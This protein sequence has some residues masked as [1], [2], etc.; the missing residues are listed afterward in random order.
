MT[1]MRWNPNSPLSDLF[2]DLF[3]DSDKERMERKSYEC[4]PATNIIEKN[5]GF[6]LQMAVPG[7]DKKD[8]KIDLEKN[9]LSIT[10][11]KTA[12]EKDEEGVKYSR[13]EFAY[14]TF[15]RSFNLPDTIDTEKIKAEVKDGIL[16]VELPKKK[17]AKISKEIKIS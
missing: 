14:G 17:E 4:A 5:E 11:E 3:G 7:V 1:M 6:E 13:R 15:C 10:S 12:K 16:T 8:I 9:I 2:D